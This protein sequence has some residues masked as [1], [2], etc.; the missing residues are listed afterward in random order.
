MC[1]N[2]QYSVRSVHVYCVQTITF[3]VSILLLYDKA[4]IE[5]LFSCSGIVLQLNIKLT[6]SVILQT[7]K[8]QRT[9]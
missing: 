7:K 1:R 6:Q 5:F 9:G 4:I 8:K 2:F 3:E